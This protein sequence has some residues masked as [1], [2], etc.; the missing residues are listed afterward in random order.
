[1]NFE[2]LNDHAKHNDILN[3]HEPASDYRDLRS[4]ITIQ[5]RR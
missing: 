3:D 4:G 5:I 2:L 1:M